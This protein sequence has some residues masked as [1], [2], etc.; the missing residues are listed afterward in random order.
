MS[1]TVSEECLRAFLD[2]L[3][4]TS[5]VSLAAKRAGVSRSAVYRLRAVSPAFSNG[6]QMAIATGYDE[7]E[8]RMLKTARFGISKPVKR[9]DGSIGRTTEF[10][11][12]Q[13]LKLLLAYKANVE[14]GRSDSGDDAVSALTARQ[15]LT[16]T[17]DQIRARLDAAMATGS[18]NG[19]G[20]SDTDTDTDTDRPKSQSMNG[21]DHGDPAGLQ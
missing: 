7:L 6:W 3:A 18:S 21:A 1:E 13:G 8:F 4:E 2:H 9:P 12:A 14:K 19:S 16:A 20:G 17:L 5:N 10:D 15:Q 11:D